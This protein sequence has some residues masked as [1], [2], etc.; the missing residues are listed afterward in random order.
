[1]GSTYSFKTFAYT[2]IFV[3]IMQSKYLVVLGLL[4]KE[5]RFSILTISSV[6]T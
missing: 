6:I 4:N 1:M 3:T 2:F 5:R